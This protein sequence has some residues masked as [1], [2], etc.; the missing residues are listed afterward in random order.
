MWEPLPLLG[1][2]ERRKIPQLHFPLEFNLL[3]HYGKE[4]G[5]PLIDVLLLLSYAI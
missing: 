5:T 4:K 3:A 1:A 2:D